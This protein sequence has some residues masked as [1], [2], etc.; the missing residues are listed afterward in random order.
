MKLQLISIM[1]SIFYHLE[2]SATL[3]MKNMAPQSKEGF[4]IVFPQIGGWFMLVPLNYY[5]FTFVSHYPQ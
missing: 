1:Q 4:V 5:T 3:S 2:T